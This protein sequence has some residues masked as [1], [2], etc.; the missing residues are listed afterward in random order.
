MDAPSCRC[1]ALA[2]PALDGFAQ[3]LRLR[4]C[5]KS[6]KR[7]RKLVFCIDSGKPRLRLFER[8]SVAGT[9][10]QNIIRTSAPGKPTLA[11]GGPCGREI[12]ALIRA[13]KRAFR[14]SAW[15]SK[16]PARCARHVSCWFGCHG[17]AAR[18]RTPVDISGAYLRDVAGSL[19]EE[20]PAIARG[21]GGGFHAGR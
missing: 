4:G 15:N 17:P 14:D 2:A 10:C 13:T 5:A 12:I 1:P 11:V 18:C 8:R 21:P 9:L 20:Y 3:S 16:T 19:A 7:F 6:K